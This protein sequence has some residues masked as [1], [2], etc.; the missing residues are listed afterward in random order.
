MDNKLQPFKYLMYRGKKPCREE[1]LWLCCSF[2]K[3]VDQMACYPQ[4]GY[5]QI[6]TPSCAKTSGAVIHRAYSHAQNDIL[7]SK[8]LIYRYP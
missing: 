7:V 4:A 8:L 1:V 6:S 5:Q 3:A 2:G